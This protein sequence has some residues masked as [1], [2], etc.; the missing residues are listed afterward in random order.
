M[1]CATVSWKDLQGQSFLL[2]NKSYA[3]LQGGQWMWLS[4]TWAC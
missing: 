2:A 1:A 3:A 4:P